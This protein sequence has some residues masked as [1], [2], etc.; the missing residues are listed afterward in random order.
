MGIAIIKPSSL[1]Y[2]VL[3]LG[4][5]LIS[6]T[7]ISQKA[8]VSIENKT[9]VTYPFSDPSPVPSLV[10]KTDMY[11]YFRF[12]GYSTKPE[13]R[14]WKVITLEN[15][16]LEVTVLPEVGGRVW[17]AVEK[18]TGEDFIYQNEVVKFRNIAMRGPWTSGGIEFNFGII[19]HSPAT[20]TPVDYVF[21]ENED[22]SVTCVVGTMDLPSRTQWR[23][24]INLLKD[25]AYFE[26]EGLWYNPEMAR[27]PYYN[28]MT[29]A[30]HTGDDLEFFYPGNIALQHSGQPLSWP[31]DEAGNEIS[32]YKNNAFGG[33]KSHHMAGSFENYFGGYFHDTGIG[34][35]HF[36]A[37][38]DMPGKKL[39]IW[40]L[41]RSGGIWED[42]LTD[43]SG[44]YIEF[45]AGRLMNQFQPS[46]YPTPLT[47]VGFQPYT[48][49]RW[50]DYW[51]PVKDIGGISSA[52]EKG[53]FFIKEATGQL[54]LNFN[55]FQPIKGSMV[56][57]INNTDQ[58]DLDVDLNPMDVFSHTAPLKGELKELEVLINGC[59]TYQW[60]K[61]DPNLLS[62]PYDRS[63]AYDFSKV[64]QLYY[65]ARQSYYSRHFAL[66]QTKYEACLETD[67]AHQRARVDYAEMLYRFGK[68]QE[69][70]ENINLALSNDFY[71]PQ[72]NFVAGAIYRALGQ[73]IDAL[74]A[75]GWAAR[76]MEFR[77]SAYT[78]MAETYLV[79]EDLWKA[80]DYA[81]KA[82]EFNVNNIMAY[83]VLGLIGRLTNK[84]MVALEA[85]EKIKD[86][87]PLNHF[88]RF[89]LHLLDPD[90]HSL[91]DFRSGIN[92]E[93]PYQTFLELASLYLKYGRAGEAVKALKAGP[94]HP[95]SDLWLAY[96]D[97]EQQDV[98]LAKML[99]EPIDFVFPFRKETMEMLKWANGLRDNWKLKYYLALNLSTL[100]ESSEANDLLLSI[101]DQPEE[102][103]FYLNRA[104][105]LK[106]TDGYE[107]LADFQKALEM[108]KSQWRTW[109]FLGQ[110]YENK[111]QFGDQLALL[112]E[113]VQKFGG[114]YVIEMDYA[115]ALSHNGKYELAMKVLDAIHVLPYEGAGEGRAIFEHVYLHAALDDMEA[116]RLESAREKVVKSLEWPENLGVGKPFNTRETLQTYL[117]G[118]ISK[119]SGDK[120]GYESAMNNLF[121]ETQVEGRRNVQLHLALVLKA[122]DNTGQ[123]DKAEALWSQI[124]ERGDE[125]SVKLI[126]ALSGKDKA[127]NLDE[128][129]NQSRA[130]LLLERIIMA[131]DK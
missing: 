82:L 7:A 125:R 87:D 53:S 29:A 31:V 107:P 40:A 127:V 130:Y 6:E 9:F 109:H 113:A 124:Q 20:A 36:A 121:E 84:K 60:K 73:H 16:F 14:V 18:S 85:Y 101:Q 33:S 108:D 105:L 49:D 22:G 1:K 12:E 58:A 88:A 34:F 99:G 62:R 55:P 26:T 59:P 24:K 77:S 67:P 23:V 79:M 54:T 11:P 42:L 86:I 57:R 3:L 119:F 21:Y 78:A 129:N 117:L 103:L 65:D 66:A 98:Y 90:I 39:W 120:K 131:S 115:R 13:D 118:L 116:G 104:L 97:K 61:E 32:R 74:E 25:R 68:H 106:D 28:W 123:K 100:G 111:R 114:N 83:Q 4:I 48:V 52:S 112:G 46:R 35:G 64:E 10:Y 91:E 17:G 80:R 93:F 19:G 5:L 43:K 56:I 94:E 8:N 44:Q 76:S 37:F 81:K 2:Y 122:M 72:A 126:G 92:N 15:D 102:A 50:T 71:D 47:K 70:L 110:Y 95:L 51:F 75:F 41:S 38:D 30:A 128:L 96:L 27:Q 69:A 89:E 63:S 45:Q